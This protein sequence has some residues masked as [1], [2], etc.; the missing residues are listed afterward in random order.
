MVQG[1][2]KDNV[3]PIRATAIVNFR[4]A[5]E[6][7][8]DDV[9]EHVR[10]VIDDDRVDAAT[11][12]E[13]RAAG[14]V[15]GIDNAAWLTLARTIRE[16]D[17]DTVVAPYLVIGGTDARHYQG[18]CDAVYRF[19]PGRVDSSTLAR[20]HGTDERIAIEDHVDTVKFYVRLIENASAPPSE[21]P[22]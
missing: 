13:P 20:V 7:T 10:R 6:D 21:D 17:P 2:T 12:E 1:G 14:A 18:L 11:I 22:G 4:L 9:L 3:L 16:L 15:S 8:P 19:K 5:P